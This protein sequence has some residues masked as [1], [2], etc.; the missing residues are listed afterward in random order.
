MGR[1]ITYKNEPFYIIGGDEVG[2]EVTDATQD[3]LL[4][5]KYNL[6]SDGSSQDQNGNTNPCA[7]SDT[8]YWSSVEGIA[9]PDSTTKKY[10]D[11]NDVNK[12]P[13]GGATS[14]ITKAKEYGNDLGV[15]GRI[16]TYEE[17][18]ILE[19]ANSE[20]LYGDK[21]GNKLNY[22]LGSVNSAKEVWFVSGGACD[23]SGYVLISFSQFNGDWGEFGD[24]RSEFGVRSVIEVPKSSID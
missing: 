14:I 23:C 10:P 13:I 5:A 17:A 7:F 18:K 8:N 3:I 15:T 21:A 24:D 20:L 9:Y 11:L 4:L 22:W 19:T 6:T 1:E 16:M 2:T 12:Y